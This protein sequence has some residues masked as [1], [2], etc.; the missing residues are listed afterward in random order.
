M[1]MTSSPH[2]TKKRRQ[3]DR[4]TLGLIIAFGVVAII[5]AILAFNVARNIFNRWEMTDLPGAPQTSSS[6]GSSENPANVNL[7]QPLQSADGPAAKPWDGASR[8]TILIMGLDF[9]D[10]EAGDIPRTDSMM[11][12]TMDPVTKTAG[13]LSI[14]RD[15]WVTIPGFDHGK[16]NTAYFLGEAYNL[17]GG[18]PA[19]AVATVEDFLG[20]PID[21]YAQVDFVAFVQLIDELGGLTINIPEEEIKVNPIGPG[22]TVILTQGV[23]VL[24]GATT[25]AYARARY[26]EGGDFDRAQRQQRVIMAV[27]EQIT[28]LNMLPT[29]ITKAPALYSELSSGIR[30]NLS[31]SQALQLGQL[32][33]N[34]DPQ[35]I[36]QRVITPDV[37]MN[38]TSP[39]G[40]SIL[41]PIPD[42]IRAIRDEVFATGGVESP[43]VDLGT[44]TTA[45]SGSTVV[46]SQDPAQMAQA[47]QARISV[48]NGTQTAGIAQTTGDYLKS[49]GLNIIEETNADQIYDTTTIIIYN[50]KPYTIDYLAQLMN[51]PNSHIYNRYD[52][53]AYTDVVVIL[54]NS[55]VSSNPMQ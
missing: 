54:G 32:G 52:P 27:K 31:L 37:V 48:Q 53:N 44:S 39:D 26:T 8:V 14:P 3:M 22:N 7:N 17:P 29:L 46:A 20:V 18:G 33:L 25:L 40:L 9:R 41:I 10:W 6:Q 21:Y 23:Q 2:T 36:K 4:L 16:I 43:V 19:L 30:T 12:L 49:Q 51:V 42:E 5:T 35:K 28:S 50:G 34:I 15:M 47:E 45:Q 24:D 38:S 55:W 13:I 1:S 11:L